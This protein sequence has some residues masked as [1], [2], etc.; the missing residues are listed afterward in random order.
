MKLYH[1]SDLHLGINSPGMGGEFHRKFVL[2]NS[3]RL[4]GVLKQQ[5]V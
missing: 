4:S 3:K 5:K 1:L 2:K